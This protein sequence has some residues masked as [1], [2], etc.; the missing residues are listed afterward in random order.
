[1]N[2]SIFSSKRIERLAALLL[3]VVSVFVALLAI[4]ALTDLF[5]AGPPATNTITV[6]GMGKATAIPDIATVSFS[7][8]G[9]GTNASTAQDEATKKNNVALAVLKEKGIAETDI[10]TTSY[11]ISPKY[12]YPQP[13]YTQPCPY[14]EERI[15]GYT[16][17]QSTQV[18][19]R[20]TAMV[21]DILSAL[22]DAGVSNL[23]G[24]NFQVEDEDNVRAEA[25]AEAIEEARAKAE[26]L[27]RDLGVRLVR[28]V[29][30]SENGGGYPAP[31]YDRAFG[32]GGAAES[33]K[34][35]P[36]IALGENEIVSQV[37]ITYEI[38]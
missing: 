9:E 32:L 26:V 30:F 16:V 21:G 11:T 31:Y 12:A 15:V 24:P 7:V 10:K 20:D 5:E 37:Y 29:S 34:V 17:N 28:V 8:L 18:K 2:G 27:A 6:D 35:A 13:C 4:N 1:M 19:I 23:Y 14:Y 22:G 25:R 33:V 36:D 3:I 38:R